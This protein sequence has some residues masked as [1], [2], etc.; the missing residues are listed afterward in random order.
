MP[1][2]GSFAP[3]AAVGGID[4]ELPL[5]TRSILKSRHVRKVPIVLKKS[6]IAELRK[7]RECSALAISAGARHG[8]IDTR[9]SDRLCDNSCGPSRRSERN[10]PAVLRIFSHQR[11]RTFSTKSANNGRW[12]IR[13]VGPSNI[14]LRQ[15]CH[16]NSMTH[17][18][19]G[20]WRKPWRKHLKSRFRPSATNTI[21]VRDLRW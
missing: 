6:K 3:Q 13:R 11:K 1:V 4:I 15:R 19:L 12:S 17:R 18:D 5:F 20:L 7:S 21:S 9:A 10:A 16:R 2:N 14:D 8:R